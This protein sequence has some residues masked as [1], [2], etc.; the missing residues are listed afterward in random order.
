[1]AESNQNK[2]EEADIDP[3]FKGISDPLSDINGDHKNQ[4]RDI[5]PP[6][7]TTVSE[8]EERIWAML[9]HLSILLNLLSGFLGGIAA[10][11]IFFIYKDRS[12]FVA[13]HAM[14]S[15]IFQSL[16]WIGLGVIGGLIVFLS[17]VF[18]LFFIPLI[19]FIPGIFIFIFCLSYASIVY[20]I[21][22]SIRVNEGNDFQYFLVGDWVHTLLNS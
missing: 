1:M 20:G 5:K 10:I 4:L 14:Q 6:N 13:Y 7:K 22:G 8:E 21:I 11:I 16:T 18:S 9:S 3:D 2:P 12:R 17:L 15:F 19:C